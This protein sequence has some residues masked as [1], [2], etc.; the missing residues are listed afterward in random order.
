MDKLTKLKKLLKDMQSVVVAYSGGLDSTFLLSVAFEVLGADNVLAVNAWSETYPSSEASAAKEIAEKIGAK[1][2]VIDSGE[3][4]NELFV[5]NN[6]DR[7]YHCKKELF[8]RLKEVAEKHG[9]KQVVDGSNKDDEK[10]YRPGSRAAEELGILSPLQEVGITKNEI[11]KFSK[12]R[13]LPTWDKP[14]FACLASRFPYGTKIT[15]E[16]L[17]RLD[18]G[19]A[20]LRTLGFK[21]VRARHHGNMVRIE[22]E[23]IDIPR[24]VVERTKIVKKFGKLGYTY[25][26]VDLIGYRTGSMNEELAEET[27]Q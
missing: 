6:K 10:D 21:Q 27:Y 22:V 15:K 25:V 9:L 26:T 24:L 23:D 2:A 14:S 20:F 19:E 16:I 7:C 4:E 17:S 12:E 11:R 5:Q 1:F 8:S 18:Q 3:L 13:N